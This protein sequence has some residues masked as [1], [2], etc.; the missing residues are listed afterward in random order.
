MGFEGKQ[1]ILGPLLALARNAER[2]DWQKT[3]NTLQDNAPAEVV[4][5]WTDPYLEVLFEQLARCVK[6]RGYG[7]R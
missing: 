5:A 7:T 4:H 3:L 6:E 1:E 2:K